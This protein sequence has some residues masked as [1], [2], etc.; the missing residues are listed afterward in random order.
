MMCDVPMMTIGRRT[1]FK[2]RILQLL[3]VWVVRA[4]LRYL[5]HDGFHCQH[6]LFLRHSLI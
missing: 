5:L 3:L 4:I 1:K 2:K 6:N